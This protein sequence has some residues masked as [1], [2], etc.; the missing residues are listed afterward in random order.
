MSRW[1]AFVHQ[2]YNMALGIRTLALRA[3]STNFEGNF[4]VTCFPVILLRFTS[5]KPMRGS[6]RIPKWNALGMSLFAE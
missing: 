2:I 3:C 1:D 5:P 6:E 4:L